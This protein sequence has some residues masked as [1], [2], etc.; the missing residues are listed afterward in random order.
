MLVDSLRLGFLDMDAA[1]N[2]SAGNAQGSA[3]GVAL[4]FIGERSLESPRRHLANREFQES[5]CAAAG[6]L[7]E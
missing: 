2:Q 6:K 1:R 3:S 5:H 4:R 7:N